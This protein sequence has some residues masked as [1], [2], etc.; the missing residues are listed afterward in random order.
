MNGY[1]GLLFWVA[2]AIT[3]VI[4][5]VLTW[6][7]CRR[8]GVT[9]RPILQTVLGPVAA[10]LTFLSI[11]GL[12]LFAFLLFPEVIDQIS[13]GGFWLVN[14]VLASIIPVLV[15]WGTLGMDGLR[16]QRRIILS[17]LTTAAVLAELAF[18]HAIL[19]EVARSID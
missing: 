19:L 5:P 10:G 4:L 18:W 11:L 13:E 8:D 12:W 16:P 17:I 6:V 15:L 2:A 1:T 7:F 3:V 14:C 9:K